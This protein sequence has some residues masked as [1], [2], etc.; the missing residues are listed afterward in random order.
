[1]ATT[2]TTEEILGPCTGTF[3]G[4]AVDRKFRENAASGGV[5]SAIT[6]FLLQSGIVQGVLASRLEIRN[7]E[8]VPVPGI[9]RRPEELARCK[10]SIYLDF[11]LGSQGSFRQLIDELQRTSHRICVV[12]LYCHLKNLATSMQRHGIPRERVITIGLF[13]SH[14]PDRTLAHQVLKRQGA[15]LKRAVAYHTKTGEGF[16]DGRLFGRSTLEYSDGSRLDFPFL[17]FTTFKNAWFYTPKK[18]LACPDQFAEVADISCGDAWYREIRRH[19]HKQTTVVTRN[20]EAR[21]IVLRMVREGWLELRIVDPASIVHSQRRV[22]GVEK[23]A[24]PARIKLAP[25]FGMKLPHHVGRVRVRDVLHSL[26][27]LGAVKAS[28][29]PRLMRIIMRLPTPVV[30]CFT[31]FVKVLEQWLLSNLPKGQG[32]GAVMTGYEDLADSIPAPIQRTK[33]RNTGKTAARARASR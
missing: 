1:M 27:M 12:G 19:R 24:L 30:L 6:A 28:N 14:A 8:L 26:V 31:L 13:C 5:V 21:K 16:R 23:A 32:V 20:G 17:E 2:F 22:A 11:S 9:A 4:Y 15:D 18:C 10:N 29:H 3:A 33:K 7:G 25:M